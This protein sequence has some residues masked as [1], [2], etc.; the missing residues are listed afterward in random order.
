MEN[1]LLLI[2]GKLLKVST[3]VP[4]SFVSFTNDLY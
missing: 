3:S 1:I 2:D 4:F